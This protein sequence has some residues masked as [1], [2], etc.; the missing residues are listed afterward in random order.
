MKRSVLLGLFVTASMLASSSF[1]AGGS[2]DLCA[3]NLQ[4]IANAKTQTLTPEIRTRV[5]ASVQQAK[6]YQAQNTEEGTKKCISETTQTL[7]EI[8]NQDKGDKT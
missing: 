1:A 5:E 8:Q 7:Q 2:D 3:T 6:A 4:A